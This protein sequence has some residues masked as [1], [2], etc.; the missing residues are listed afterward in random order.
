MVGKDTRKREKRQSKRHQPLELQLKEDFTP[1]EPKNKEKRKKSKN[2]SSEDQNR[3]RFVEKDLSAKILNRAR[4]QLGEEEYLVDENSKDRETKKVKFGKLEDLSD[5]DNFSDDENNYEIEELEHI[6]E[7]DE[8]ALQMFMN[9]APAKQLT[10]ADIIMEK[11]KEKEQ[12][13]QANSL[14][15]RLESTLDSKIV[16][17]YKKVGTLLER[18]TSGKVPKAFKIIPSLS[19]WEEIVYLTQPDTWSPQ[20]ARQATRLFASNLNSRMAQRF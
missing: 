4:E 10:L 18:Y 3:V 16:D 11:I 17:V 15:Q 6:T 5:E 9:Q 1:V 7:E 14:G 19:N 2:E 8:M 20:A 13:Q 12:Q